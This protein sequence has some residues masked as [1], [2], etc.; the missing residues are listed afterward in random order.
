M[1]VAAAV[2]AMLHAWL[3]Y[4]VPQSPGIGPRNV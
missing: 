4:E 3:D 2:V 1:R